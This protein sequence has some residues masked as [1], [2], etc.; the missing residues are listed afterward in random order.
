[1]RRHLSQYVDETRRPA[2]A[3]SFFG[4]TGELLDGLKNMPADP[5]E[6]AILNV[7]KL[8]YSESV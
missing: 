4:S 5:F 8:L 7:N 1:M 2:A 3:A 6:A